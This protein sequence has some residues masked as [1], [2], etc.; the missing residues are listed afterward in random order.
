MIDPIIPVLVALCSNANKIKG[1][2]AKH[3]PSAVEKNSSELQQNRVN[4]QSLPHLNSVSVHSSS[5]SAFGDANDPASMATYL[6]AFKS[7]CSNAT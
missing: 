2:V 7:L 5:Q 4:S 6:D 1:L 3:F